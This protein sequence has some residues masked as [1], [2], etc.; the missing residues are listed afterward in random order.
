VLLVIKVASDSL[1]QRRHWLLSPLSG[2]CELSSLEAL[3]CI[4]SSELGLGEFVPP[5]LVHGHHPS[6][7]CSLPDSPSHGAAP[8]GIDLLNHGNA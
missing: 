2:S 5:A 3:P 7:G 1:T 4:F 8:F 6:N